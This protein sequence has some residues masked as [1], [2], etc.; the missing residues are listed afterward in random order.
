MLLVV[1]QIGKPH[2]IRGEVS[3]TVRTDEPEERFTAGSVF[4]TE[5][6]RDRRVTT[7]PAS[8]V[9]PGVAYKIPE[10]LVLDSIRWHQ[11]RGIAQFEGVLDRNGAEALRGVLLQ[12]DSEDLTPPED[13]DEFHDHQLVGLRVESLDG[14][15]LGTVARIE[16]APASDLI[17]LDKTAGGTALIPF[18]SRIV[19]EVDIKGGRVVVDLPEGL[20]D[21]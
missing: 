16:H 9:A 4:T 11:G 20:L 10:T 19:P 17:V 21:L 8:A 14:A 13:P 1:G 6:P 12:V 5:V 7:G 2:G 15:G 3:V 18:V